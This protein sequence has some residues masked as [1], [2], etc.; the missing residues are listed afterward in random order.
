MKRARKTPQ[1]SSSDQESSNVIALYIPFD[2]YPVPTCHCSYRL[3]IP[4]FRLTTPLVGK[5]RR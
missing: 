3:I 2:S 5:S 1:T 4:F